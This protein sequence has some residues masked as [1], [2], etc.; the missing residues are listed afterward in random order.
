MRRASDGLHGRD[1]VRSA[2]PWKRH[3][4][5]RRGRKLTKVNPHGGG[6]SPKAAVDLLVRR[7]EGAKYHHDTKSVLDRMHAQEHEAFGRAPSGCQP[8]LDLPLEGE[9]LLPSPLRHVEVTE[10]GQDVLPPRPCR[11]AVPCGAL[12]AGSAEYTLFGALQRMIPVHGTAAAW[13]PTSS[14]A[15]RIGPTRTAAFEEPQKALAG[16]GPTSEKAT[17]RT[18]PEPGKAEADGRYTSRS[19]AA[20]PPHSRSTAG[21]QPCDFRCFVK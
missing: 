12:H 1:R 17:A 21:R 13:H 11:G 4:P 20:V 7:L 16:Y 15:A 18:R 8:S 6:I 3:A 14:A 2:P 19:A 9:A 5:D 10:D